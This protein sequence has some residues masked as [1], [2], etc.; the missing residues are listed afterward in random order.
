MRAHATR[1]LYLF[2]LAGCPALAQDTAP[3]VKIEVDDHQLLMLSWAS[4][5]NAI[6][7]LFFKTNLVDQQGTVLKAD[8]IATPPRNR[9]RIL[10]GDVSSAF[11]YVDAEAVLEVDLPYTL[12]TPGTFFAN[13]ASTNTYSGQPTYV[14]SFN[15]TSEEEYQS[16]QDELGL[17]GYT[18]D[19]DTDVLIGVMGPLT[20]SITG[21]YLLDSVHE[22]ESA[23][24][25]IYNYYSYAP[26]SVPAFNKDMLVVQTAHHNKPVRLVFN[27]TITSHLQNND[28][29]PIVTLG[30]QPLPIFWYQQ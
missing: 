16:I 13:P 24:L 30:S 3:S 29:I 17:T 18:I 12:L 20:H 14:G 1:W 15:I 5:S 11:F 25:V 28:P 2:F 7:R 19:F 26:L 8:T 10:S 21:H 23:I 27:R 9:L 4:E 22:T 6:Y